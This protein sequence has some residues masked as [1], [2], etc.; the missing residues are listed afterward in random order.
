MTRDE[1]L[2]MPAGR[3]MDALIMEK[4][5]NRKV[6]D[7]KVKS[8]VSNRNV[9]ILNYSIAIFS[10]WM[11][12]EKMG[13]PIIWQEPDFWVCSFGNY[14]ATADTAPLAICRAA[15]LASLEVA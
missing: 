14:R 9:S 6:S 7:G 12:V 11:V 3:E 1:I 15:L 5:F 2:K 4:V 8:T 10:A 13:Y